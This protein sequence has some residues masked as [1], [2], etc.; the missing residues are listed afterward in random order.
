M[1][2]LTLNFERKGKKW[3]TGESQN[4]S[5]IKK[6]WGEKC[7][8]RRVNLTVPHSAVADTSVI[9]H[10]DPGST[11]NNGPKL[12][13][14]HPKMVLFCSQNGPKMALYSPRYGQKWL[15]RGWERGQKW[16]KQT[17]RKS[18]RPS[19]NCLKTLKIHPGCFQIHPLIAHFHRL[20]RRFWPFCLSKTS[21]L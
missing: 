10:S 1:P 14:N 4:K 11:P 12:P 17:A 2:V 8:F 16:P 3:Q 7:L 18:S 15:K 19:S 9:K 5:D 6:R 13:Q 20:K 21:V